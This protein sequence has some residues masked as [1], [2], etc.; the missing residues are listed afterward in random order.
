MRE[1]ARQQLNSRGESRG[2]ETILSPNARYANI[3]R[4]T[5]APTKVRPLRFE[6]KG[7]VDNPSS[8]AERRPA[9][10]KGRQRAVSAQ[11]DSY[12]R[13]ESYDEESSSGSSYRGGSRQSSATSRERSGRRAPKSA[14]YD[15]KR[16]RSMRGADDENEHSRHP[17]DS[18]NRRGG[19]RRH[20]HH[21]HHHHAAENEPNSSLRP[22][23]YTY[24]DLKQSVGHQYEL[25]RMFEAH[26][27]R[28]KT[29][30]S[31]VD[32]YCDEKAL[33]WRQMR[34][35]H[36]KHHS[37]GGHAPEF[38]IPITV[39]MHSTREEV[40]QMQSSLH[41]YIERIDH[42]KA[43][44][45]SK[46]APRTSYASRQQRKKSVTYGET[47]RQRRIRLKKENSQKLRQESGWLS[48]DTKLDRE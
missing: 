45:D 42:V 47:P 35:K 9:S 36:R 17:G 18:P 4:P 6:K 1:V 33:H 23:E 48:Y 26:E 34:H 5:S 16:R 37:A 13:H 7:F 2:D 30:G 43:Y 40:R 46:S 38:K 19:Q 25:S 21:H 41:S 31:C 44:V 11:Q 22:L 27:V 32:V 8:Q 20:H 14:E 12:S 29:A 39:K 10:S 15:D 28:V 24:L 3:D